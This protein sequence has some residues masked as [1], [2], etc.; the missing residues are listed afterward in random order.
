LGRDDDAAACFIDP[1]ARLVV[2]D[3][4]GGAEDAGDAAH[5]EDA[6]HRSVKVAVKNLDAAQLREKGEQ[7]RVAAQAVDPLERGDGVARRRVVLH[8]DDR[9]LGD[10]RIRGA[11]LEPFEA[12]RVDVAP[13]IR[14]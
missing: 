13:R 5:F 7:A 2:F 3:D 10:T 9:A 8:D 4:R 12:F 1:Y 6:G 14:P 11:T